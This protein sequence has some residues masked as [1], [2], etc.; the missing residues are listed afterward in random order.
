M[1]LGNQFW[2]P[3]FA[4]THQKT[5]KVIHVELL[6]FWRKTDAEA[7]FARLQT[8]YPNQFILGISDQL[9][10]DEETAAVNSNIYRFR[11]TPLPAEVARIANTL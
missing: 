6:G 5:G 9:N 2:V 10:L 3:D 11:R 8:H 4:L 7:H 1:P